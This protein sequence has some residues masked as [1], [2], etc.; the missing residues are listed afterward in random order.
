[1]P[2]RIAKVKRKTKETEIEMTLDLDGAGVYKVQTPV[3]FLTHMLEIFSKHSGFDLIL[4]AAGDTDVDAHHTV[5]DIGICLGGALRDAL[6]TKEGIARFGFAYVPLD[7]ALV[8]SV[9]DLSGRSHLDFKVKLVSKKR[10]GN[11]DVELVEDFFKSFTDNAQ[12]TL[13]MEQIS[14]RNTHHIIEAAFKSL[15]R[16]L[17]AAAA[18]DSK[19]HG[20]PSTKGAL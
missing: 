20:V 1:M 6:G 14:G 9:V 11:F 2:N 18:F 3:P 19:N 13:H 4:K 10:V 15:A 8:R 16:A 17:R 7:E 12:I 5:E